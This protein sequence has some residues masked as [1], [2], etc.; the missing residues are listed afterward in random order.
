VA[1]TDFKA[2]PAPLAGRFKTGIDKGTY[3]NVD[4]ACRVAV[5][6]EGWSIE[7]ASKPGSPAVRFKVPKQDGVAVHFAPFSLPVE[8]KVVTDARPA[9]YRDYELVKSE[10]YEVAGMKGRL[11]QFRRETG[12]KKVVMTE[13]L[14]SKGKVGYVLKMTAEAAAHAEVEPGFLKIA[15]GFRDLQPEK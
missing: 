4:F 11:M 1:V 15:A 12:G 7:D 14:W 3:T 2:R 9:A 5:P 6:A 10:E 8:L 13:I